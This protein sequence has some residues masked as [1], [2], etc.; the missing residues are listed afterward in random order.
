MELDPVSGDVTPLGAAFAAVEMPYALCWHMG[1][2]WC[3]TNNGVGTVGKVYY[4]RPG[5]DTAWTEDYSMATA[6]LGGVDSMCSYKGR[7]FVG[8]EETAG[9]FSKVLIRD[10]AGA[11]TASLTATGGTAA[12][13]NGFLAM[14]VFEDNLYASYW[15]N[16]TTAVAKIYKYD[17]TSWTTAYTGATTTLK[18]LILLFE[19]NNYLYAIGGGKSLVGCILSSADGTTWTDLTSAIHETDETLLPMWGTVIV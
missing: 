17:N 12:V 15:N 4:F 9:A 6:S 2:L 16:D 5:I 8:S 3:G 10:T 19:E 13:N 7:L 18:P 1:R 14:V 11:Y